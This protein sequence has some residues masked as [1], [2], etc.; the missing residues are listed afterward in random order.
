[1]QLI[2][3]KHAQNAAAKY[4]VILRKELNTEDIDVSCWSPV[5]FGDKAKIYVTKGPYLEGQK[6]ELDI[7]CAKLHIPFDISDCFD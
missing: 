7:Y 2:P 1:M 6:E 4:F 3:L 5:E